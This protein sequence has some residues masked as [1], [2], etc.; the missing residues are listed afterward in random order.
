MASFFTATFFLLLS[1]MRGAFYNFLG[2]KNDN[3]NK[4]TIIRIIRKI[5]LQFVSHS[6]KAFFFQGE[7][8]AEVD[9]NSYFQEREGRIN[10]FLMQYASSFV[11]ISIFVYWL[12]QG[13]HNSSSSLWP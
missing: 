1:S 6:T 10:G 3:K 13:Q 9:W 8:A 7:M 4:L 11:K 5:L 12:F 2:Y